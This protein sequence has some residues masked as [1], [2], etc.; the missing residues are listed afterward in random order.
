MRINQIIANAAEILGLGDV[1][2]M[3]RGGGGNLTANTNYSILLR[4]ANLVAS[5]L[6]LNGFEHMENVPVFTTGDEVNPFKK[7]GNTALEYGI[8]A[9]FA[10]INGMFNEA[11]VWNEKLEKQLFHRI[12]KTGRSL[13]MPRSF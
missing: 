7:L 6:A 5:N 10:F 3:I 8:L 2:S 13:K 4:C 1:V 11:Q 9:E 12:H